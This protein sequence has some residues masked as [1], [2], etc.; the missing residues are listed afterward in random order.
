MWGAIV[1]L[2]IHIPPGL[3]FESATGPTQVSSVSPDGR[4]VRIS[5]VREMRAGETLQPPF[6]VEATGVQAG[7]QTLRVTVT[8]ELSPRGVSA[9]EETTVY[10]Q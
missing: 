2:T 5:P 8:S 1:V 9:Q 10:A 7:E 4:T 3:R 6:R